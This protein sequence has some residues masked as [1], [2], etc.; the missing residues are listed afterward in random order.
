[1]YSRYTG[2]TLRWQDLNLLS[3]AH[4]A[5]GLSITLHR[6]FI[7]GS[8]STT[9]KPPVGFEPTAL[10]LQAPRSTD[11]SYD[12]SMSRLLQGIQLNVIIEIIGDWG[13]LITKHCPCRPIGISNV[14]LITYNM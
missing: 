3:L 10:E 5:S 4:G 12:G 8:N 6:S 14:H 2:Y 9:F 11:L 13:L 7:K 1:M